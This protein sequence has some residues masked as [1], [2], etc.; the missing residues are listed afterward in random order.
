MQQSD[1]QLIQRVLQ[2]DEDAFS[3]LVKKYQKGIH[4]L[5]WRKIGDFHIAQEITQDAFLRAY[6]KLGA[7]KN[8]NAFAGWLYVIVARLCLDWLR[9]NRIPIESLDTVDSS[10]MDK[11]SYSQYV[12]DQQK[13]EA[14]ETLREVVKEL[15]QKLPESERT[16]MTLHYL[17]EMTIKAISEFLGVS[18]NTVKSR[19]SRARNR[20][21]KQEDVI[22]EN[23]GSFQLPNQ[24]TEHIMRE[25]SRITPAAPATSK[26]MVPWAALGAATVLVIL[27]LGVG[28]QYLARFQKP[29]SFEALSEPTV[30]IVDAPI[31]IDIVS[32]PD[33]RRRFG[34]SDVPS[35]SIGAGTQISESTSKS[36]AQE[37][38][39]KS[40]TAQWTQAY[41]PPAGHFRDIFATS[42]GTLYAASQTG[43]YRLVAGAPTWTRI[44]ASVPI[45]ESLMPMVENRG[46]LYIVS[47]DEIFTSTDNGQTWNALC[48]RP[49]GDPVGLVVPDEARESRTQADITMYLA[50]RDGGVFRSTDSGTHWRHLNE[51]LTV[52]EKISALAA[53]GE[54]VFVGTEIGLYRLDSG[55]W[56]KSPVDTSGAVCSLAVS[57]NN[58]YVGTGSD[59]LVTLSPPMKVWE[60]AGDRNASHSIKILHSA[61]LG[62]TW[63]DITPEHEISFTGPPAGITVLTIGDTL[64]ALGLV[65]SRSTDGGQTWSKL[66]HDPD[67]AAISSLPVAAVD[68]KTFYKAGVFGIHRT[69][70]GGESWHLFM[71]G[72]LGTRVIDLISFNGRLYAN[73][74]YE[75]FQSTDAGV[76][77]QSVPMVADG[78]PSESV[79]QKSLR[80]NTVNSTYG[81]KFLVSDNALYFV[82]PV[83]DF[84][85]IFR[86]STDSNM[87]IPVQGIPTF[88]VEETTRLDIGRSSSYPETATVA[89]SRNVFYVEYKR[90]LFKWRLGDP[91]WINTG[92]I[93]TSEAIHEGS[94]AGFK[95][96]AS[97]ETI[98][99]GKRDGRLFQALDEGSNWRDVTPNLPLRFTR[100]KEIVFSGSTVYVA[101]DAGVLVSETGE[102]WRVITDR[103]D[104]WV[105][106]TQFAVDGT[107]VYG[108]GDTSVYRL[109]TRG[110]WEQVTPGVGDEI[111]A[112]AVIN[113]RLY[114]GIKERGIFHISIAKETYNGLP[115]K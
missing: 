84:L 63:T 38:Q 20:L 54:T 49:K 27:M 59:L 107:E 98:Y 61:D 87:L 30:E 83:R 41:G 7:L 3:P 71:D 80:I 56:K 86:L 50:L 4:A 43:M 62:A 13:S 99:V 16:V 95:I 85:Q 81:S 101:T 77:W 39:H 110:R 94:H 48:A 18:P 108:V 12:T 100:F 111:V 10:E 74:S 58:L 72:V 40:S 1:A 65:S 32:K 57:G 51:G 64:L 55:V 112:L 31:T 75:V 60:V 15:L 105:V 96:A 11:E 42:E 115:Y 33:I 97:R 37:E 113:S 9:K 17:G 26:P 21:R 6:R 91:E 36:T 8:P 88:E 19:L 53:V 76:S 28:S 29:Y 104:T 109:D 67:F 22:R 70:D 14:D 69:T 73:N 103:T 92:L 102:H 106:I 45:G 79:K 90:K 68:E 82:L 52:P 23:L 46:V 25:V 35:K 89:I 78:V 114:S 44:N 5:A 93:D 47:I 24:L 2:G 66:R 34:R